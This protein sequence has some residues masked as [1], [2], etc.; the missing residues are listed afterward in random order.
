[1]KPGAVNSE[2]FCEWAGLQHFEAAHILGRL[3]FSALPTK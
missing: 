2:A 3:G 1:M